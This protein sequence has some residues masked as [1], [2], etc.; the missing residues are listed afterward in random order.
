[1]W[2]GGGNGAECLALKY[3]RDASVLGAASSDK[4]THPVSTFHQTLDSSPNIFRP[5]SPLPLE[6]SPVVVREYRGE[7][8]M[9][10]EVARE[11]SVHRSVRHGI[12][13]GSAYVDLMDESVRCTGSGGRGSEDVHC[14]FAKPIKTSKIPQ[15]NI[16]ILE[17]GTPVQFRLH[18]HGTGH[19]YGGERGTCRNNML[20]KIPV[21]VGIGTHLCRVIHS[22]FSL[23]TRSARS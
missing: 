9:V 18:S 8:M 17:V 21:R 22:I 15:N 10:R 16:E 7:A 14:S 20:V 11:R 4:M 3:E 5:H 19:R 23:L 2:R 12:S 13:K 6:L 1:M